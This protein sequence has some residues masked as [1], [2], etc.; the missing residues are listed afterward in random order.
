MHVTIAEAFMHGN[1]GWPSVSIFFIIECLQWRYG[2]VTQ[3]S[4]SKHKRNWTLCMFSLSNVS[5]V[6]W[7]KFFQSITTQIDFW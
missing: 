4:V 2:L 5:L 7:L 6:K 1:Y 3:P